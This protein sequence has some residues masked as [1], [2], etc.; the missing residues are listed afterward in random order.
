MTS[1]DDVANKD[2]ID[3]I[4]EAL[5]GLQDDLHELLVAN[6]VINHNIPISN[7]AILEYVESLISTHEEDPNVIVNE[8]ITAEVDEDEFTGD[9][10][11]RVNAVHLQLICM[12]RF[13]RLF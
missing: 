10:A 3:V 12:G 11:I 6:V 8:D 2:D 5:D 7:L 9:Q 4:N 1:L 13:P